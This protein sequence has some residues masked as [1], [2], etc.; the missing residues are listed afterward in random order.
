MGLA[1]AEKYRLYESAV[2]CFENDINFINQE[3]KKEFGKL[4]KFLREDFGGTG[5]MACGWVKQ[6]KD[7]QARAID[8]DDDPIKYGIENHY[9]ALT[10]SE[11]RRMEYIK[12]NVLDQYEFVPDVIVAFNFSYFIFKSRKALLEYFTQVRKSL[13]SDGAFFLDIFGGTEARQLLEEETEHEEFTYIWDCDS[14]NPLT[15][16]C[17]YYIHFKTHADKKLH[18]KV[19]TYDWRMWGLPEITD[20]LIDAG[21][22]K[23]ETY[24]EGEDGKGSGDGNFYRTKNAGNCESWVTYLMATTK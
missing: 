14:Y 7:R 5:A 2:Q 12:G 15:D 16:D 4:P 1:V 10:T 19:F 9:A 23:V 3:F 24:W 11:K 18:K 13:K 8:L 20:I 21:F 22:S 17:L 6:G